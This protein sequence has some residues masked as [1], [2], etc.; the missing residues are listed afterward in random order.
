MDSVPH[1]QNISS[2][3]TSQQSAVVDYPSPEVTEEKKKK[4]SPVGIACL[5]VGVSLVAISAALFFSIRVNQSHS[6]RPEIL[7]SSN[8][9]PHSLP[10]SATKG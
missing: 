1:E 2:Q 4:L 5:V 8:S 6:K 9:T 7:D 3:P 10:S